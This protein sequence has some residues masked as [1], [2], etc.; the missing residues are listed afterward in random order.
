MNIKKIL[1][2]LKL[3]KDNIYS[4]KI[5]NDKQDYEIIIRDKAY[6]FNNFS[7][8]NLLTEISKHH[9]IPVMDKEIVRITQKLKKNSIIL[10]VGGGWGWHWRNL[11][12]KRPDLTV[13]IIDFSK[14]NLLQAFKILKNYINKSIY[15]VS[16]DACQLPFPKNCFDLVWSVGVFQHIPDFKIAI[17]ESYK[18]LK[19]NGIFINYSYNDAL[20]TKLV[21]KILNKE[22]IVNGFKFDGLYLNRASNNQ[23]KIIENIF[24]TCINEDRYTELLFDISSKLDT[25]TREYVNNF[26]SF[27]SNNLIISRLIARQRSFEIKKS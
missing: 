17:K 15:L 24:G 9:S 8:N 18:V 22:Y 26:D 12:L 14:N 6:N 7:K 27:I 10:D 1:S 5:I 21:Y 23:K 3:G 13:I 19:K 11:H 16:G 20:F 2:N 4:G 25:K